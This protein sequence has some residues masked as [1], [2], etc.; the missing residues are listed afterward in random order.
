[1]GAKGRVV[2]AMSGGVDSS[3]AAA[4]LKEE[5]WDKNMTL[6]ASLFNTALIFCVFRITRPITHV[7]QENAK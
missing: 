7:L 5:G 6:I 2:V 1:M 3:V 4:L